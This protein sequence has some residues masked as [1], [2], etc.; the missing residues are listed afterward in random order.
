MSQP[1]RRVGLLPFAASLHPPTPILSWAALLS[2]KLAP[3]RK[4]VLCSSFKP[5]TLSGCALGSRY[6]K[7]KQHSTSNRKSYIWFANRDNEVETSRW[8]LCLFKGIW[9]HSCAILQLLLPPTK[10]IYI[11]IYICIYI[12][13]ERERGRGISHFC[14]QC[15]S[16]DLTLKA[17]LSPHCPHWRI[18]ED[19]VLI[20]RTSLPSWFS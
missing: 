18:S 13:I 9:L 16:P 14:S 8:T 3:W 20:F 2:P 7:C 19:A 11:Y 6:L 4:W 17:K 15:G 5:P 1:F 12:Y 10:K